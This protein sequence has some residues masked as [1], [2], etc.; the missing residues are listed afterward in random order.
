MQRLH[1]NNSSAVIADVLEDVAARRLQPEEKRWIDKIESTRAETNVSG[2]KSSE[3]VRA[4]G[5][6]TIGDFSKEASIPSNWGLFLFK[7]LRQFHPSVCLEI[8][9]GLGVSAMYQTAAL[10]L[11][12]HGK[13]VSF[14]GDEI[15]AT[16]AKHNLKKSNLNRAEVIVGWFND[17]HVPTVKNLG[18]IDFVFVDA[19]KEKQFIVSTYETVLPL[20]SDE[21]IIVF[22]DLMYYEGVKQAWKVITTHLESKVSIDLGRMGLIKTGLK[23]EKRN[24]R[25]YTAV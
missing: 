24:Y 19:S 22:D 5:K 10:E 1:R 2:C 13:L 17:V 16:V 11:N 8:G 21:A 20:L 25:I 14:E 12:G 4:R 15:N 7:L 18:C 3:Y 6:N 23:D 9:S